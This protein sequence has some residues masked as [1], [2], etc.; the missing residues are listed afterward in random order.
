MGEMSVGRLRDMV[1][2]ADNCLLPMLPLEACVDVQSAF[3][4]IAAEQVNMPA[5]R[6]KLYHAQWIRELLDRAILR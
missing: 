3:S 6:R 1:D 5:E 4:G 2:G